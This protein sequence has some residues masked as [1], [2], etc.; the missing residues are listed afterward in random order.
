MT[1]QLL[2]CLAIYIVLLRVYPKVKGIY[3]LI[4]IHYLF[5]YLHGNKD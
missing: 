3:K 4:N 5:V 1:F 2:I